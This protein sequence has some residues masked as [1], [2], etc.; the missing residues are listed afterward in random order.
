MDKKLYKSRR[1]VKIDG[2]CA[3]IADYLRID[4]TI[5]RLAWV[6][7][8]CTGAGFIAYIACMII[9]PREPGYIDGNDAYD[10]YGA[11]DNQQNN[12]NRY[13]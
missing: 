10:Q 2:V 7:F 12:D 11:R 4:P 13:Q 5:V 6:I 1:N 9:I 3:G 8:L